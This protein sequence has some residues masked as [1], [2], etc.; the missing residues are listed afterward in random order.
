MLCSR[1]ASRFLSAVSPQGPAPMTQTR[2]CGCGCPLD[3]GATD[4]FMARRWIPNA[5]RAPNPC[6]NASCGSAHN[7]ARFRRDTSGEYRVTSAGSGLPTRPPVGR[8]DGPEKR[9]SLHQKSSPLSA[10]DAAPSFAASMKII[11]G[12]KAL[13]TGAASGIG[14]AI[15]IALAGEGADLYLIDIDEAGLA[16][17]AREVA[18]RGIEVVTA[19]CGLR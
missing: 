15:A 6:Q 1:A 4:G 14:R 7:P 5:N 13:I 12:K 3:P 16:R 8:S 2:G 18:S 11:R 9:I 17:T 10:R 19:V